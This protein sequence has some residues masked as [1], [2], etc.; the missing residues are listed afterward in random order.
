MTNDLGK[1]MFSSEFKQ[2]IKASKHNP[3]ILRG[4]QFFPN[5]QISEMKKVRKTKKLYKSK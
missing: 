5:E 1:Y 2:I 4:T 3:E